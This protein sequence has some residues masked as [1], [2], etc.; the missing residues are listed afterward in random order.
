MAASLI[1]GIVGFLFLFLQAKSAQ[2]RGVAY[3]SM[4]TDEENLQTADRD[5]VRESE[6]LLH[7]IE[8]AQIEDFKMVKKHPGVFEIAVDLG[9][10]G[11]LGG[12]SISDVRDAMR[13]EVVRVLRAEG[14]DELLEK[15]QREFETHS[16]EPPLISVEEALRRDGDEERLHAALHR[17]EEDATGMSGKQ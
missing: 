6:E 10:T 11:L 5:A 14:E 13:E 12:G 3:L 9:P 1:A 2:K 7:N 17:E 16:G 15:V 8:D 4:Q